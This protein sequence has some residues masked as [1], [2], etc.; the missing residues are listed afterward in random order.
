MTPSESM[1]SKNTQENPALCR[2][3]VSIEPW[4]PQP[5]CSSK[6]SLA[7]L[8]NEIVAIIADLLQCTS[9]ATIPSLALVCSNYYRIA[10]Y[11]QHRLLAIDG[12]RGSQVLDH[13]EKSGIPEA[14]RHLQVRENVGGGVISR[15]CEVI[16]KMTGLKDVTWSAA[17][18]PGRV[19][20]L[21]Q[22]RP[23][24]RLHTVAYHDYGPAEPD[25]LERLQANKNLVSISVGITYHSAEECRRWTQPLK[26]VLLSCP[27]LRKLRLD[28]G[29]PRSECILYK[30]PSEYCG[31]GF[32]SEERLPALED[33]DLR[34]YPFGITAASEKSPRHPYCMPY[35]Q[36]Y[37]LKMNER[38][39]WARNFDWS[40]LTR[41]TTHDT[42]FALTVMSYLTSLKEFSSSWNN[43]A[44]KTF[45]E[46]VP[47]SLESLTVPNMACI[48]LENLLR[49]KSTLKK[50][51]IHQEESYEPTWLQMA[52]DAK[53]LIAIRDNCP[54]IEELSLDISRD[55]EWPYEMLD[56]LAG[57][58]S[59][60]FLK[61][62]FELG[63][64][65]SSNPVQP[66]VHFSAVRNLFKYIHEHKTG[67]RLAKLEIASGCP[68]AVALGLPAGGAFWL[69]L[70]STTFVCKLSE[71]DD[72]AERGIFGVSCTNLSREENEYLERVADGKEDLDWLLPKYEEFRVA[73]HGPTPMQEWDVLCELGSIE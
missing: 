14:V 22:E 42:Q 39:F 49:H 48:G 53:T 28:F 13:V 72:E 57:F 73:C 70:N 43:E 54:Y 11:A 1:S 20:Q 50:L 62:W 25:V 40:R 27:N 69:S 8:G 59:L 32:S 35:S 24:I 29:M 47:S 5:T 58:R 7:C 17:G 9:P 67:N 71:R 12:T 34:E 15:L 68:P 31:F 66:Y 30:S 52:I 2:P 46:Q 56:I 10:R 4:V 38:D 51:T 60:R 63:V 33:L 23:S 26:K 16:P 6:P 64:A 45:Y 55:G 41:L 3:L 61:I 21:L 65:D 36:G 44:A 37:P 19:L 18:V